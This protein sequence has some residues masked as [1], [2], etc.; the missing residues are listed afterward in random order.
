MCT[1]QNTHLHFWRAFSDDIMSQIELTT[2]HMVTVKINKLNSL[3][4]FQ[5]DTLDSWILYKFGPKGKY[6]T[7]ASVPK[8]V[9]RAEIESAKSKFRIFINLLAIAT[10][11]VTATYLVY[12]AR[13]LFEM[14]AN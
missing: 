5:V 13:V 8:L 4:F 9:S 11:I 7:H 2:C 12:G 14:A 1:R 6:P 3:M 10:L